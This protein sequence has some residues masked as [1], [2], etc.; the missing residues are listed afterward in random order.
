MIYCRTIISILRVFDFI[1]SV[2]DDGLLVFSRNVFCI[3]RFVGFM[4]FSYK[5][6]LISRKIII[7]QPLTEER[8]LLCNILCYIIFN[9]SNTLKIEKIEHYILLGS[10]F[11]YNDFIF[12]KAV[13]TLRCN[14][15]F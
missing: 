12:L 3:G 7:N 11:R 9:L 15:F 8:L 10:S 5:S 4:L 1:L 13:V 2:F 14:P 6:F